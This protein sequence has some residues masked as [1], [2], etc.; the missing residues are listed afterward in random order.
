MSPGDG[1]LKKW[2]VWLVLLAVLGL[3]LSGFLYLRKIPDAVTVAVEEVTLGLSTEGPAGDSA[4][5][6]LAR[7]IQSEVRVNVRLSVENPTFVP[8]TVE[9]LTWVVIVGGVEVGTGTGGEAPQELSRGVR[10]IDTESRIPVSRLAYLAVRGQ[11]VQ[12]DV[13][14]TAT[15]GVLGFSVEREF[16]ADVASVLKGGTLQEI[17][18][19]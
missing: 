19:Q 6:H 3:C 11:G 17:L 12:V 5:S 10:V 18:K 15:I 8:A 13:Q 16:R 2:S 9:N 7:A 14:G 4:L 1:S